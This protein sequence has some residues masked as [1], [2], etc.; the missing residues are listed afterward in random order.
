MPSSSWME[1]RLL[2]NLY[3]NCKYLCNTLNCSLGKDIKNCNLGGNY[4]FSEQIK[5]WNCSINI[6]TASLP[7]VP[8]ISYQLWD[9]LL[10]SASLEFQTNNST[11]IPRHIPSHMILFWFFIFFTYD[12]YDHIYG[13]A[14]RIQRCLSIQDPSLRHV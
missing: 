8:I 2:P 9:I 13:I 7:W 11:K 10:S 5:L 12:L 4:I 14:Q 1:L 6:G 3:I